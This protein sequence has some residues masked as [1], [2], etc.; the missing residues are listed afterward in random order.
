MGN[1]LDC[2]TLCS[3]DLN[4]HQVRFSNLMCGI[5]LEMPSIVC[6]ML[7]YSLLLFRQRAAEARVYSEMEH[8]KTGKR[9]T[10]YPYICGQ[11]CC[12]AC[13][14]CK[15]VRN[16]VISPLWRGAVTFRFESVS[17]A[18]AEHLLSDSV[19]SCLVWVEV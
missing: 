7:N 18:F 6:K 17:T 4:P 3:V 14:G 2:N 19:S 9:P 15:Q 10:M 16:F 11:L 8:R 1:S 12:C 13:C 5:L